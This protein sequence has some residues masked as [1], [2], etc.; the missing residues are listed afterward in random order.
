MQPKPV[1]TMRETVAPAEFQALYQSLMDSLPNPVIIHVNGKV[2]FA[3]EVILAL[4]GHEKDEIVG[5]DLEE[6]LVD[7]VDPVNTRMLYELFSNPDVTE[8][9]VE[10]RTENR[11]MVLK[12]F[13]LRNTR[14]KYKGADAVLSIL[15]DITERKNL[16]K[17]VIGKV[18]EAEEK[19]RKRFAEDLHDDLGPMLSSIKIHLGMLN[20]E[21]DPE[22]FMEDLK[23]C[24]DL[25]NETIAKMRVISNNLAP[26]L[27]ENFGLEAALNL[28][29]KMMHRDGTFEIEVNSNL[30][31]VRFPRLVE[32]H[33]YRIIGELLNNSFKHSGGSKATIEIN[34]MK[35]LLV[36]VYSD[37]GKGYDIGELRNRPSGLGLG[38]IVQRVSLLDGDIRFTKNK[39]KT[40]V[41]ITKE[42][43]T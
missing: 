12:T 31:G 40:V 9:E 34:Y 22:R 38:N 7:P 6:I 21:G 4:A 36:L 19:E 14:I 2:V 3:N 8:E 24:N 39:G 26:R 43:E 32:L 27:I 42:V 16:E 10:F 30:D 25:L 20:R 41:R 23:T 29:I 33:F 35:G 28:L 5:K 18:I 15:F 17:Y 37:N 1:N 13:L 11:K